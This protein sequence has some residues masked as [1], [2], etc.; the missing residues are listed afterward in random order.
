[1][2][3][4]E[5]KWILYLPSDCRVALYELISPSISQYNNKGQ[6][7]TPGT[8]CPTLYDKRVGSFT[9]PAMNHDIDDARD[10]PTVYSP[11]PRRP[12]RL[13][14]CRYNYKAACTFSSVIYKFT[15]SL[16]QGYSH[17][18]GM[19]TISLLNSCCHS[20]AEFLPLSLSLGGAGASGSPFSQSW[21]M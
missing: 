17:L 10:G 19:E 4:N 9:S 11:Y 8:S 2:K 20:A 21:I 16:T 5:M 14:I 1:M 15:I 12:G 6:N 13:T 7:T 18:S 3:W